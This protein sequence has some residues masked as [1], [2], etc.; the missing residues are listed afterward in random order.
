MSVLLAAAFSFNMIILQRH[1]Q[2]PNLGTQHVPSEEQGVLIQWYF[3][4]GRSLMFEV[5]GRRLAFGQRVVH[6]TCCPLSLTI[7]ML[8]VLRPF[9]L[10]SLI[11]VWNLKHNFLTLSPNFILDLSSLK[12][13]SHYRLEVNCPEGERDTSCWQ[14]TEPV[15]GLLKSRDDC[16]GLRRR[17]CLKNEERKESQD[18]ELSDGARF[19]QA[20][21]AIT[22][23]GHGQTKQKISRCSRHWNVAPFYLK[24]DGHEGQIPISA[25]RAA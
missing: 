8:L 2:P 3:R 6:S 14:T 22:A 17:V 23:P 25:T 13:R 5:E 18:C 11:P 1:S 9:V 21:V 24:Y 15:A 12:F 7:W 16:H 10:R 20:L 4:E 19:Y